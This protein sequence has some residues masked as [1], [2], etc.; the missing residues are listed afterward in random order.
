[1]QPSSHPAIT[2]ALARNLKMP[3]AA[4]GNGTTDEPMEDKNLTLKLKWK[5]PAVGGGGKDKSASTPTG[6]IAVKLDIANHITYVK[7]MGEDT[8]FKDGMEIPMGDVSEAVLRKVV[9]YC[10]YLKDVEDMKYTAA[11]C[12]EWEKEF[13]GDDMGLLFDMIK[14]ANYLDIQPMFDL[15]CKT[16][17]DM[18]KGKSPE[19]ITRDFAVPN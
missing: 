11:Q 8:K 3:D 16:V 17:A 15:T 1:M 14:A 19:E 2:A 5:N 18:M 6:T 4:N 7:S 12:D 9:D 13:I 10:H